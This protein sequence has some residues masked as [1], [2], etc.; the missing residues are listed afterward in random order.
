MQ[1]SGD[2]GG[3]AVGTVSQA[4]TFIAN[5]FQDTLITGKLVTA[6]KIQLACS[7]AQRASITVTVDSQE[8][9]KDI[10]AIASS[11][12]VTLSVLIEISSPN[13]FTGVS[14]SKS[15][16]DLAKQVVG[17]EGTDFQGL[18][19]AY[20]PTMSG[21]KSDEVIDSLKPLLDVKSLI[22]SNGMPVNTVSAGSTSNYDLIAKVDGINQ[23][24]AGAYA[25]MDVLNSEYQ[26]SLKPAAM[27]VG[28]VGSLPRDGLIIGDAGMKTNGND[29]GSVS[30]TH[31]RAHETDT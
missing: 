16:L 11:R 1:Y 26:S 10:S 13:G 19:L 8:N 18:I 15:A 25:L 5:G 21:I 28:T 4:E 12:G 6:D 14:D 30:Y 31:L 29:I 9:L 7:L 20:S 17:A 27:V 3:V 22:E 23:V 2:N 24:T